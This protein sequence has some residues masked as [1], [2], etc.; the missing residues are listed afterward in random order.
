MKIVYP[1]NFAF[2]YSKNFLCI[3]FFGIELKMSTD[4]HKHITW[5]F[6][7]HIFE[8]PYGTKMASKYEW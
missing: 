5:K 1:E 2:Q 6:A 3:R 7:Y 8:F 4:L